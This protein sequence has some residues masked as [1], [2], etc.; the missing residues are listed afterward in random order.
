MRDTL[1]EQFIDAQISGDKIEMEEI[2]EIWKD[3]DKE[4]NFYLRY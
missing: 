2:R 3:L 4:E 1:R